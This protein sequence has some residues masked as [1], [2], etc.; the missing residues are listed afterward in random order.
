VIGQ[1]LGVAFAALLVGGFGYAIGRIKGD[2]EAQDRLNPVG[3][4]GLR[5]SERWCKWCGRQGRCWSPPCRWVCFEVAM[6]ATAHETQ[7]RGRA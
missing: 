1:V 2:E 6:T 7:R 5:D 3:E 4:D